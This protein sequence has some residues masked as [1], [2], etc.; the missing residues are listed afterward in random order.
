METLTINENEDTDLG[1][2]ELSIYR[3]SAH[4]LAQLDD[5]NDHT[6]IK[7]YF[8]GA[9]GVAVTLEDGTWAFPDLKPGFYNVFAEYEG[10]TAPS[11][12]VYVGAGQDVEIQDIITFS[13]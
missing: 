4:G 2:L 13:A 10:Y 12:A 5:S 8:S 3:G 6:G 1:T 9:E 7:V 11:N